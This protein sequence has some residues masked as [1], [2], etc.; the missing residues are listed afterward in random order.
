MWNE[1]VDGLALFESLFHLDDELDSLDD[2]VDLLD[3][4]RSQTVQVG[5]VVHASDG[6]RQLSGCSTLLEPELLADGLELGLLVDGGQ[7][8]DPDVDAAAHSGAEVAGA[9]QDE[10][11]MGAPHELRAALLDV[12]LD[13]A[14]TC[15]PALEDVLHVSTHLHG[16]DTGVVLLVHPHQEVLL[17][18][19][20]DAT[21][22]GEVTCHTT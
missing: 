7:L 22:V 13:L 10:A 20:P 5:D 1:I 8:G 16:D 4:G 2:A 21:A 15:H 12:L 3:L 18:V 9:G 6:L 17:V 19:V 11:E 14:E